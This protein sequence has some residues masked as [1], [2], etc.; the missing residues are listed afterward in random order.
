[1]QFLIPSGY[2]FGGNPKA[3]WAKV[4]MINGFKSVSS[5]KFTWGVRDNIKF[6]SEMPQTLL[7]VVNIENPCLQKYLEWKEVQKQITR[8]MQCVAIRKKEE[9]LRKNHMKELREQSVEY[10]GKM[11]FNNLIYDPESNFV[12]GRLNDNDEVI[13][14]TSEISIYNLRILYNLVPIDGKCSNCDIKFPSYLNKC[15]ECSEL[16]CEKCTEIDLAKEVKYNNKCFKCNKHR[17]HLCDLISNCKDCENCGEH[18]VLC[19]NIH[20]SRFPNGYFCYDC[21]YMCSMCE[22]VELPDK[23]HEDDFICKICMQG[24][25]EM[26]TEKIKKQ[27][28]KDL[29]LLMIPD[30]I[31]IV[32]EYCDIKGGRII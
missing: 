8:N 18:F 23:F 22:C 30:M 20:A 11:R 1:M 21:S 24:V 15:I 9:E 6:L 10:Q 5:Q 3:T 16:Y 29:D 4:S 25:Q 26:H 31:A 14:I 13:P 28:Y 19:N 17:C 32:F 2:I 12:Y 7:R 27:L